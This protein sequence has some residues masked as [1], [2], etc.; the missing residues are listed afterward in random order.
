MI[1]ANIWHSPR[2]AR[3]DSKSGNVIGW[4]DATP[5]WQQVDLADPQEDV[6]N[7]IAYDRETKK[8][9]VTGKRWPKLF[10]VEITD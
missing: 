1:Y 5:L 9:Y 10:E 2:I 3:I 4:I 6:L 8:L 7:G